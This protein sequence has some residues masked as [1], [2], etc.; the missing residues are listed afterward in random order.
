[1]FKDKYTQDNENIIPDQAVTKYI[2]SKITDKEKKV[3]YKVNLNALIAAVL[4]VCLALGVVWVSQRATP[5]TADDQGIITA[6]VT[7]DDIY[8]SINE[9]IEENRKGIFEYFSDFSFLKGTFDGAAPE[10]ATGTVDDAGSNMAGAMGEGEESSTTNNQVEGVDEADIV[11]NDGKYIYRIKNGVLYIFDSNGGDVKLVSSKNVAG[12]NENAADIF[13]NGDRVAVLIRT[14]DNQRAIT[15]I[16]FVDISDKAAPVIVET[17]NQSGNYEQSRMIGDTVYVVSSYYLNTERIYKNK[18]EGYVPCISNKAMA[19]EDIS[20]IDITSSP[21][22]TVITASNINTGECTA[23]EAVLGNAE[24]IYADADN[25]YYTFT[26]FREQDEGE[27]TYKDST[28]IVKLNLSPNDIT[29][30]ATGKVN[31]VP[32]NQ[33]SM[34]EYEGNLRIVT[35]VTK[36]E[37]KEIEAVVGAESTSGTNKTKD[38]V[39]SYVAW[40][41]TTYNSLYVL[42]KDLKIIGSIEDLAKDERVYSVRF[43]GNIGYF[44]TFRQTDPLFTVDLSDA[45]NPRILSELKIPG[46]SEYLHPFGENLL[47]GFGMSATET[48]SVTGVKI[49]MFDVSDPTNV[50]EKNVL[51]VDA[52]YADVSYNHKAIMVDYKKNIIAFVASNYNDGSR[53]YVYGYDE[54]EGFFVR[55]ELVLGDKFAYDSRFV[56]IGDNFYLVTEQDVTAFSMYDFAVLSHIEY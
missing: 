43:D 47:F 12:Y 41:S 20:I 14:Y 30:A 5:P 28:N 13:V 54:K 37:E 52:D 9:Y 3:H 46:F 33:F 22:Y 45:E 19:A 51:P 7:Y 27:K 18:P 35:T 31:G 48:G 24:N 29:T 55:K 21:R 8:N 6:A 36:G 26:N 32:L 25:L 50:T 42:D 1:M 10:S 44:V 39:S 56:W 17:V 11:K 49:S 2:R 16:K 15:K 40:T 23:S 34:D 38:I 53:M 4:T